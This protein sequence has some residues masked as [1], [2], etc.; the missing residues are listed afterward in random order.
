MASGVVADPTVVPVV[1]EMNLKKAYKYI[2]FKLSDDK[3]TIVIEEASQ[4]QNTPYLEFTRRLPPNE[5][6]YAIFDFP[7]TTREGSTRS[8]LVFF[9]WNPETAPLKQKMVMASSADA[10]KK[11]LGVMLP[12][13]QASDMGDLAEQNVLEKVK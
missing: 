4:N 2:I 11:S 5:Y 3:K 7:Y 10:F 9:K 12:E 6:R 8:K 13:V 1:Q